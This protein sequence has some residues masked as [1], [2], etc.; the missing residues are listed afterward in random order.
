M[1]ILGLQEK[2]LLFEQTSAEM[3]CIEMA[4]SGGKTASFVLL[5]FFSD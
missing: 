1:R 5:L 2:T 3:C 4:H